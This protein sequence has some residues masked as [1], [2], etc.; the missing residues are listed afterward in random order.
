MAFIIQL[1]HIQILGWVFVPCILSETLYISAV[2]I[3]QPRIK[4]YKEN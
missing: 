3:S 1:V 4:N 2:D